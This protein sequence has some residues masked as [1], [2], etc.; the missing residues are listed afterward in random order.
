MKKLNARTVFASLAAAAVALA[1][2]S[3]FAVA[4]DKPKQPETPKQ[5]TPKQ[6]PKKEERREERKHHQNDPN[7][8]EHA[9][10]KKDNEA[11]KGGVAIGAMAPDFTLTDTD[12]KTVTLSELLKDGN[13]VSIEFYNSECPFVKK[14][15]KQNTT[16]KDMHEKYKDK[17]VVFLAICSSAKGQQGHGLELNKKS[18]TDYEIAY[19]ILIDENA[20]VADLYAAK[21]TPHMY[22]IN[23]DGKLAYQGAID[24]DSSPNTLGKT[25]YVSKALDELLAGS[26]VSTPETKAYGCSVKRAK[27]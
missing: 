19:P 13:M 23:K 16:F 21:V 24:D 9:D 12:G 10:K 18:K 25:N 5:E 7:K 17:K 8:K 11:K 14:H 20:A 4:D 26:N 1:G 6:E 27:N 2:V 15:H 22:V 3:S